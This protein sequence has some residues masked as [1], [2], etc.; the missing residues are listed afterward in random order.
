MFGQKICRYVEVT[1]YR[2]FLCFI[3][4]DAEFPVKQKYFA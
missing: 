3:E 1:I 2:Q 4:N